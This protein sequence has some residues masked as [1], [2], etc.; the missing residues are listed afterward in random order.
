MTVWERLYIGGI[1][2]TI[3]CLLIAVYASIRFFT[4][5]SRIKK[6]KKKKFRK[7]NRNEKRLRDIQLLEEGKKKAGRLS[8]LLFIV[9]LMVMGGISYGSYYQSMNLM[10]DDSLSLIQSHYLVRDFEKQL[11]IAKNEEDDK[12]NV[13]QNIRYLSTGMASY[14]TKRASQVNTEE[15]QLILNQYYNAIKQLGINASTQ[16][17]N[18][19][20]NAALVDEFLVDIQRVLRYEKKV[21]NYYKVNPDSFKDKN[22]V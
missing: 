10:K 15:G 12:E 7:K 20:G 18:F 19:F 4:T 2:I 8:L 13:T 11:L 5:Q 14:G 16:T 3:L 22:K 9:S 1:S 6:I 21:F 17:R